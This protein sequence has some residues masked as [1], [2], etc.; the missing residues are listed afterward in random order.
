MNRTVPPADLHAFI[1]QACE[2]AYRRGYQH[3]AERSHRHAFNEAELMEVHAWRFTLPTD[4]AAPPPGEVFMSTA[5]ARLEM[6][7]P[8]IVKT[9]EV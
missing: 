5:K 8:D 3:A 2:S 7:R 9:L 4:I 1:A 6:E